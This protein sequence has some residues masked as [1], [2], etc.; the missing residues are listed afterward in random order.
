MA[1]LTSTSAPSWKRLTILLS[2]T[3]IAGFNQGL[4]LP[5]LAI[6]LDQQGVSSDMNGLNSMALYIG[7]FGMMFFIE[8]PIRRFGYKAG[9]L[10]GIALA[11]AATLLFPVFSGT[12]WIWFILR[13]AVGI[14]DSA[15]HYCTQLWIVSSASPQRRG[16]VISL[17]G[18]AYGIGFSLGPIGINLANAGSWMPFVL[19]AVLFVL[20]AA[21]VL[22]LGG[23]YP[24]TA[25]ASAES[26]NRFWLI[27]RLAWFALLP[28][29]LY[30]LL[31]ST[32]NS[33]FPLYGLRIG[34][35]KEAISM[36]LPALGIGSLVVMFP[37]GMLSDRVGRKRVLMGC[38]L[39]AGLLFFAVPL[40][41]GQ[42]PLLFVLLSLI[43]G[44]VGSFFSLGLAY[45]GDLLP[46]HVLP[47]ANVIASIHF[48]IGSLLGPSIGGASIQYVS[49]QSVFLLLGGAFTLFALLGPLFRNAGG[50]AAVNPNSVV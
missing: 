1:S 10:A 29:I 7:T 44:L 6:L 9:I 33:N 37:L 22:T 31:E 18:M 32:M 13:I 38:A 8:K 21:F 48:S 5:L 2:V 36:L 46:R 16:R 34:L 47:S 49:T 3:L 40:A 4:L 45:A 17:Y 23:E 28:A 11:G 30:G 42:V 26:G 27:Y 24:E 43:G 14:G 19:N 35:S 15:L 12:L 20:V 41:G 25:K 50:E 39:S